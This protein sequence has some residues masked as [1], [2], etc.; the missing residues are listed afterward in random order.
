MYEEDAG[1]N[2]SI[3]VV[4]VYRRAKPETGKILRIDILSRHSNPS[5]IL[6]LAV[7][8]SQGVLGGGFGAVGECEQTHFS[9]SEHRMWS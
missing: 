5:S 8:I 6:S 3:A 2:G 7:E 9:E 4:F 1:E